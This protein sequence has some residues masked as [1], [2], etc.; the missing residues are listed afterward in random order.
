MTTT[1][2]GPRTP[3]DGAIAVEL[4]AEGIYEIRV[5]HDGKEQAIH[6]RD[7]QPLPL[8][9]PRGPA[10]WPA[11]VIQG[12]EVDQDVTPMKAIRLQDFGGG[13]D[14]P[15][16]SDSRFRS[17]D[18]HGVEELIHYMLDLS[19]VADCGWLGGIE[20]TLWKAVVA[21]RERR[22]QIMILSDWS[23]DDDGDMCLDEA[24][25]E[26]LAFLARWTDGWIFHVS[27]DTPHP[28]V[29]AGFHGPIYVPMADW[30]Q[31]CRE[32]AA[33]KHGYEH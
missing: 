17:P 7:V 27:R 14:T 32:K 13:K 28:S 33:K 2:Q 12:D 8:G 29:P 25:L 5:Q 19:Q 20:Y 9:G 18:P 10:G 1:E 26:R 15:Y 16:V 30:L 11:D 31:I 6:D 21:W 3:T 22:E 24:Y 4:K 23:D